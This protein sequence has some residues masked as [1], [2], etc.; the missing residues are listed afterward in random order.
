MKPLIL[1]SK[2][3][4]RKELLELSTIPF[5][6]QA[7]SIEEVLD[8]SIPIEEAIIQLAYEKAYPVFEKNLDSIILGAD[9]VVVLDGKILGKPKDEEDAIR[10]LENLSGKSHQVITGVVLLTKEKEVKFS[11]ITE[12]E[13]YP[14][15]E[16]E[17]KEYVATKE[18]LDKAGAYG[19]QGK[20][21]L[22]I[23]E[24]HGDY[25]TVMGLPISR[26]VRE[27]KKFK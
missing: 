5:Q 12:V 6:V 23:K 20:G 19:I 14:L 13:M 10:M 18:P 17:I 26:V 7:A 16:Q 3:P 2:S 27:L 1:A 8:T 4:R 11:S 22:L 21:S 25:Y 24:I 15:E 9:T